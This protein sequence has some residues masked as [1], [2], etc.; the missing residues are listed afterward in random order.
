MDVMADSTVRLTLAKS[1][2]CLELTHVLDVLQ[3][4]AGGCGE[5]STRVRARRPLRRAR[6]VPGGLQATSMFPAINST[7]SS[8]NL[9]RRSFEETACHRSAE[10]PTG[11]KPVMKHVGAGYE[12]EQGAGRTQVPSNYRCTRDNRPPEKRDQHRR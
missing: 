12:Q 1:T 9:T 7:V 3:G 5:S 8:L 2:A 10:Q 11:R 6:R 4:R